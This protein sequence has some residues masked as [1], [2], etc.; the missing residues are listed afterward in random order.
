MEPLPK[1]ERQSSF[2]TSEIDSIK[3][4]ILETVADDV[5]NNNNV[6]VKYMSL[7]ERGNNQTNAGGDSVLEISTSEKRIQ[8][9]NNLDDFGEFYEE[10][11]VCF[12]AE[13]T[14]QGEKPTEEES[15]VEI[16][17]GP[18]HFDLLKLL[19]EG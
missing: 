16:R 4:M 7:S 5:N 3:E 9:E 14:E 2:T 11:Q 6:N 1:V 12:D 17:I 10:E 13:N 8:K 15:F 19:G 18:Q